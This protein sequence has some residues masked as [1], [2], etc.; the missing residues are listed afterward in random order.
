MRFKFDDDDLQ[1]LYN[2]PDFRLPRLGS[3]VTKQFRKKMQLL[4]S[5]KDE[6]DLYALRGLH[7]EKLV[8]K[9]AGQHSIRLNDQFRLI[10]RFTTDREGRLVTVLEITD[11]H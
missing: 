11:Y 10:L 2:D 1:R 9:R 7:L 5:A 6:R 4:A 8:K 3:D